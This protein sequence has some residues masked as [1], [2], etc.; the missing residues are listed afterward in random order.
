MANVSKSARCQHSW[1]GHQNKDLKV[2]PSGSLPRQT[3]DT[4][5]NTRTTHRGRD[6]VLLGMLTG[7]N[8]VLTSTLHSAGPG[9][10]P[11]AQELTGETPTLLIHM[12]T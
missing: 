6:T 5:I 8:D 9:S 7:I 10:C 4:S 11:L 1:D 2:I 3:L 12:T